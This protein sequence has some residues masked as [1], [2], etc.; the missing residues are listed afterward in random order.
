V[1]RLGVVLFRATRSALGIRSAVNVNL[2]P[3]I[4]YETWTLL[5]ASL[6]KHSHHRSEKKAFI[7]IMSVAA[8]PRC[9]PCSVCRCFRG[10]CGL[11]VLRGLSPR[12][13]AHVVRLGCSEP[14][15]CAICSVFYRCSFHLLTRF[16]TDGA[17]RC[18]RMVALRRLR[19]LHLRRR[20]RYSMTPC[21]WRFS[22][23]LGLL[24]QHR[25]DIYMLYIRTLR[26]LQG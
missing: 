19:P 14:G 17:G 5:V 3:P 15:A 7:A 20:V 26:A 10:A 24:L 25:V 6:V 18:P 1:T 11:P 13:D 22:G 21:L 23:P 2:I 8:K 9:V 16:Y 12:L 4:D